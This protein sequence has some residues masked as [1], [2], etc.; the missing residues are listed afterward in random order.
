MQAWLW[1]MALSRKS[2]PHCVHRQPLVM[3]A[4]SVSPRPSALRVA[5]GAEAASL[6][7]WAEAEGVA[8]STGFPSTS[9]STRSEVPLLDA[10]TGTAAEGSEAECT[11]E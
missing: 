10:T 7:N 9:A 2:R 8:T 3:K 5:A 11:A 6:V 4:H 1:Y